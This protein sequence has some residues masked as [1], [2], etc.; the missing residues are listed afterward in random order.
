[1]VFFR[2]AERSFA[3]AQDRSEVKN[4]GDISCCSWHSLSLQPQ[5][6]SAPEG[7]R[8][9]IG[10]SAPTGRESTRL[11]ALRQLV[12]INDWSGALVL[13]ALNLHRLRTSPR[14]GHDRRV[15]SA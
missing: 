14:D 4:D 6:P 11:P 10:S 1:M 13:K 9:T 12:L 15:G 7:P 5:V 2:L 3:R 8:Q